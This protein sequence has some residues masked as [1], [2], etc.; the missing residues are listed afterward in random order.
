MRQ[1]HE[2]GHSGPGTCG[3][4]KGG[5]LTRSLGFRGGRWNQGIALSANIYVRFSKPDLRFSSSGPGTVS[6]VSESTQR[7]RNPS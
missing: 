3:K 6:P 2:P 5:T 1:K 4:G 7:L